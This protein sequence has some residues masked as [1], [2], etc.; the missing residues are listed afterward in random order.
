MATLG[1]GP[2]EK[3]VRGVPGPPPPAVLVVPAEVRFM[4]RELVLIGVMM[5][6]EP[7]VSE[8]L[9]CEL[10]SVGAGLLAALGA[11]S[12]LENR[13]MAS[14]VL[15]LSVWYGA[16][17]THS[18]SGGRAAD[19]GCDR[20]VSGGGG[21]QAAGS[22]LEQWALTGALVTQWGCCLILLKG[23]RLGEIGTCDTD[24]EPCLVPGQV[25]CLVVESGRWW[26]QAG[27]AD[28]PALSVQEGE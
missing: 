28:R 9:D 17:R 24:M 7:D 23:A 5:L 4:M 15:R 18:E 8:D 27:T 3:G 26:E 21:L 22:G 25:P 13:P 20:P 1:M 16:H 2:G 6:D 14:Y 19:A 11:R 10:D 12:L